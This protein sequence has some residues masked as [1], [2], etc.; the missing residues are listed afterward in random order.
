[1]KKKIILTAVLMLAETMTLITL[2][3]SYHFASR[4][5]NSAVMQIPAGSIYNIITKLKKEGVDLSW[6][7]VW[8]LRVMGTPKQGWID[9]GGENLSR[10]DLYL[11]LI[12]GKAALE[13]IRFV[14]GETTVMILDRL[15]ERLGLDAQTLRR[16]YLEKAPIK[17][18]YLVPETY[19]VPMGIDETGLVQILITRAAIIHENRAIAALGRY[20]TKQWVAYLTMASVIEKEAASHE[21]MPLIA[22][23]IVNRIERGMRLQMD[24][25]L[26]YGYHSRERITPQRIREDTSRYNTYRHRGLP[27]E[28]VCVVSQQAIE[29]AINPAESD[30]LY[31]VRNR[32]GTH[33]FTRTYREHLREVHRD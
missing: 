30:Y 29:A 15:A 6:L 18:G 23:V 1:M 13:E 9:L 7:D 14:P 17:E 27:P 4:I 2:I 11:G 20:E 21:E 32:D 10:L 19:R 5:E 28:P 3:L 26:N 22:S 12:E 25:T 16:A 33:T 31:F 8:F 24:G